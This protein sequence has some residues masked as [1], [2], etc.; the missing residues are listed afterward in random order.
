MK[1]NTL[2]DSAKGGMDTSGAA[3]IEKE[4]LKHGEKTKGR[5][6]AE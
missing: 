6:K 1:F 5:E 4:E 3:S 2:S